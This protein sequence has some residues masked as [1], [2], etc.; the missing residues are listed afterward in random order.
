L[1]TE[2]ADKA[3]DPADKA[4][5]VPDQVRESAKSFKFTFALA[6]KIAKIIRDLKATE[7][8]GIDDIPTS[9]LKKGV[10]VLAGPIS[11]LVNRLL[12]EGRV[13][14]A[15]KVGKVFP[16]FKGKGK[17]RENPASYWPVLILPAMSKILVMS[18]KADLEDHLARVNSLPGARYGFRPKRSCT[19]ALAHASL[20]A[21][22]TL[23][24]LIAV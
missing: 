2:V 5:D 21:H 8:M 18:V 22:R 13:P 15:F 6:G 7:A 3:R 24:N 4:T 12:A 1:A 11:H 19:T 10:E 9:V 23:S 17:A 20:V 14:E 16:I